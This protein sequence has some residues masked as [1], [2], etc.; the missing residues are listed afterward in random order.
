M[1]STE[2]PAFATLDPCVV[3]TRMRRPVVLDPNGFV[4]RGFRAAKGITYLRVGLT[5]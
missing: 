2:W 1:I 5:G 3:A 4:A